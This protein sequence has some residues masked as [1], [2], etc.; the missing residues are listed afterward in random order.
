MPHKY[1]FNNARTCRWH[2][3]LERPIGIAPHALLDLFQHIIS[4]ILNAGHSMHLDVSFI[5][6]GPHTGATQRGLGC[7]GRSA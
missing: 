6:L 1:S 5:M 3:G 7:Q 4:Q 2:I